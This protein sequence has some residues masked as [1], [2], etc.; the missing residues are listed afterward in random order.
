MKYAYTIKQLR[1][2]IEQAQGR[3]ALLKAKEPEGLAEYAFLECDLANVAR[4]IKELQEAA[5][6]LIKA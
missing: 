1:I 4:E 2:L 3:K 5:T 6:V